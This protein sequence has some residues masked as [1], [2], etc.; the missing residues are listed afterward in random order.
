MPEK[1]LELGAFWTKVSKNG[2]EFMSG[3]LGDQEVVVFKND[4]KTKDS[5]QDWRVYK[6][7]PRT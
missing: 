7:R 6:S 5:E 2:Q 1:E 4:R 3:K